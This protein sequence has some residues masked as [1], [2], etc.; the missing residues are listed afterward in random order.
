[1]DSLVAKGM[2]V[3]CINAFARK[4]RM[5]PTRV[6][7]GSEIFLALLESAFPG[8]Q[9]AGVRVALDPDMEPNGTAADAKSWK[10]IRTEPQLSIAD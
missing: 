1:M 8:I 2:V 9:V 3:N 4:Y 5:L 7:V 6:R 10:E